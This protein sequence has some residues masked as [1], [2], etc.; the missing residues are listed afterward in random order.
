MKHCQ[1]KIT[2]ERTELT[3]IDCEKKSRNS[4]GKEKL[5]IE[6]QCCREKKS[7]AG[8][9]IVEETQDLLWNLK[10]KTLTKRAVVE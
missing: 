9:K 1:W 6:N 10:R 7:A 8:K 5:E 3:F 2:E 4:D